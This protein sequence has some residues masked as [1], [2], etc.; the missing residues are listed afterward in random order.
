MY[1]IIKNGISISEKFV[2]VTMKP[3]SKSIL[4]L[5]KLRAY[6][7]ESS[8]HQNPKSQEKEKIHYFFHLDVS[9]P[10]CKPTTCKDFLP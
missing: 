7:D 2:G 3:T 6:K 5:L 10:A 8:I 9:S 1:S 4:T